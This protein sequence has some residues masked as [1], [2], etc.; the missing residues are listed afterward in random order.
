MDTPVPHLHSIYDN[1]WYE[2]KVERDG[3]QLPMKLIRS[4]QREVIPGVRAGSQYCVS[5]RFADRIV[6]RESSFGPPQ[7][8]LLSPSPTPP[9][10]AAAVHGL[11]ISGLLL[12]LLFLVVFVT[13]FLYPKKPGLPSVLTSV[14]HCEEKLEVTCHP[15]V[16]SRLFIE[17]APTEEQ[18]EYCS[19]ETDS[20]DGEQDEAGGSVHAGQYKSKTSLSSQHGSAASQVHKEEPEEEVDLLTLTFSR[21]KEPDPSA[22]LL[23]EEELQPCE[24][25]LSLCELTTQQTEHQEESEEESFQTGYMSHPA[26][27]S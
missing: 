27:C 14:R 25:E 3:T 24:E 21:D 17:V 15:A 10:S 13:V 2:L 12:L 20:S 23:Y 19:S 18:S 16:S 26:V 22:R 8:V 9:S 7:C 6:P 5:V 4:L 1:F 11:L